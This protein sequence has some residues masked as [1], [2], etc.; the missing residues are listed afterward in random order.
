MNLN[1]R[2]T[3]IHERQEESLQEKIRQTKKW[4]FQGIPPVLILIGLTVT[5]QLISSSVTYSSLA[6]LLSIIALCLSIALIL[7][8]NHKGVEKNVFK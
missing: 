3:A 5:L 7:Y 6:A 4:I 2:S 1:Y 8:V